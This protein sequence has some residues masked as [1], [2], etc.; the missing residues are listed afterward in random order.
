MSELSKLSEIEKL[1]GGKQWALGYITLIG[2]VVA[3]FSHYAENGLSSNRSAAASMLC[4]RLQPTTKLPTHPKETSTPPMRSLRSHASTKPDLSMIIQIPSI[5]HSNKY[6]F[7][8]LQQK[9][10]VDNAHSPNRL[11]RFS[12]AHF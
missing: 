2:F 1:V 12:S 5:F 7:Y 10:S 9:S 3:E 11:W 4:P 8:V 6:I